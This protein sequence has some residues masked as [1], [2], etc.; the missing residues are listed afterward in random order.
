MLEPVLVD[1]PRRSEPQNAGSFLELENGRRVPVIKTTLSLGKLPGNDKRER[2]HFVA[3]HLNLE[4]GID[5]EE[6]GLLSRCL[7]KD[8]RQESE[9]PSNYDRS[10]QNIRKLGIDRAL[11]PKQLFLSITGPQTTWFG[12]GPTHVGAHPDQYVSMIL[13]YDPKLISELKIEGL[14][15]SQGANMLDNYLSEALNKF[16][17]EKTY[18]ILKRSLCSIIEI[19]WTK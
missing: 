9:D 5:I 7:S 16:D 1:A 3:N 14:G 6:D 11:L 15:S 2:D 8:T 4:Q 19:R 17:F 13:L 18:D 12:L 10:K